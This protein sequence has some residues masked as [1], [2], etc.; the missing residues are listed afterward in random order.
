MIR[1]YFYGDTIDNFLVA[2]EPQIIGEL[3]SAHTSLHAS[4]QGSQADAWHEEILL[5][6]EMLQTYIRR[7]RI[8]LSTRFRAWDGESTSYC[9]SME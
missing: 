5:L 9:L 6:K 3:T 7:G 4:L 1:R 8:F 2:S